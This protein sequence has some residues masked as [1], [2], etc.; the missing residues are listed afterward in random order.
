MFSE[1]LIKLWENGVLQKG[2]WETIYMTVLATLFAYILGLPL[3]VLLAVTGEGGIRPMPVFNKILGFAVN[4]F[5]TKRF[6]SRLQFPYF[7]L[8]ILSNSFSLDKTE[9]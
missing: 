3:G 4:I 5:R 7:R 2:I 6:R 8:I 1:M 9:N